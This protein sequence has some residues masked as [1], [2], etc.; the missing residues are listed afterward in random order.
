MVAAC[1]YR[2]FLAVLKNRQAWSVLALFALLT[3]ASFSQTERS[4]TPSDRITATAATTTTK[5]NVD[6][7]GKQPK[8]TSGWSKLTPQQ[9]IALQP[10]AQSWGS[11][12]P[13]QRRK[14]LEVSRNFP[15]M[16][17]AD[18]ANMHSRMAEWGALSNRERAEARLNFAT[19]AELSHELT[20]EERKAKWE[21]YQSLSAQ[22]KEN[23]ARNASRPPVGAATPIR[24]VAPQ[25]LVI[26][27][28]PANS[29]GKPHK[30]AAEPIK[31]DTTTAAEH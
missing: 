31:N 24:P 21:A 2:D 22:E 19:T 25:K 7:P 20:L 29:T 15:S 6:S 18:K 27:P 16:P 23:L 30:I 17:A 4:N 28:A 26:L 10:L 8:S 12:S 9:K 14:W 5:T 13:G 11:L 3:S 1:V